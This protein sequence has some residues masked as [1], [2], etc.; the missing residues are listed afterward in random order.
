MFKERLIH[1]YLDDILES[2]ADAKEYTKNIS[3]DDFSKDR[4]TVKASIRCLEVIGEAANKI[5]PIIRNKYPAIP[6][7]E[8]IGMRN[9]LIHEY[10]GVDLD[11][12][13]QTI[14]EDLPPLEN[15]IKAILDD[16]KE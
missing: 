10:F 8:I 9:R 11:I 13:W 15:S 2:V 6:W 5:P 7:D 4:K 3:F 14:K 16:L 1:D 12:I